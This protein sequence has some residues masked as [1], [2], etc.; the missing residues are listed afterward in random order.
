VVS[1][2]EWF[3]VAQIRP[4]LYVIRERLDK[5]DPRFYTTYTNLYLLLGDHTAMLID[6][7]SGVA[8]LAELVTALIDGR[9]LVVINTHNHFDH[10]GSNY[11]FP[12]TQIHR[13]DFRKL[14]FPMPVDFLQGSNSPYL[15]HYRERQWK[16]T[17]AADCVPLLG[18][19]VFDLG[20]KEV[21]LLY[22]PGH[23][24]GSISLFSDTQEVFTGDTLHYGAVFLPSDDRLPY[25]QQSVA[26]LTGR[27]EETSAR[28]F[29]GHENFDVGLELIDAF[30]KEFPEALQHRGMYDEFLEATVYQSQHFVFVRPTGKVAKYST[31]VIQ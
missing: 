22:T 1:N 31:S 18:N 17:F 6:T 3:D 28:I 10:V 16:M 12:E 9:D 2:T 5:I 29:P 21:E 23:T 20:N 8:N 27:I 14:M 24:P 15:S 26:D 7:G 4:Y 13:W 30:S 11:Q 19:E 25:Y